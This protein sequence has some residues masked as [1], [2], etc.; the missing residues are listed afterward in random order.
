MKKKEDRYHVFGDSF[1]WSEFHAFFTVKTKA[2]K[3]AKQ[4]INLGYQTM[5]E[6]RKL[7]KLY[8]V[9]LK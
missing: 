3:Y 6:D 2:V 9:K 7:K 1:G 8:K 5:L 4:R